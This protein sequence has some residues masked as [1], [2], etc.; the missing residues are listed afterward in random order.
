MKPVTIITLAALSG[1]WAT[2][3]QAATLCTIVADAV[4]G[5]ALHQSGSGCDLRVPPASTFKLTLSLI[6]FDSGL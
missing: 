6:G 4:S 2:P 5:T 1:L 3:S